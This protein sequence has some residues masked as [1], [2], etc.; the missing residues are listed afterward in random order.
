MSETPA[1][2]I[3]IVKKKKAHAAHHGGS[4]KVA[5]AD[6]VTAMMAFFLVMWII[7]MDQSTRELIQSYFNDP[8]SA[9]NSPAGISKLAAGGKKAVAMGS[10]GVMSGR[11]WGWALKEAQEQRFTRVRD[12]LQKQIARRPELSLLRK[13]VQ[14]AVSQSGLS[15]ELTEA[16]NSLFFQSGADQLSPPARQLLTIVAREL[17]Q[18]ANPV[19]IE[20]HTD[21]V[22]YSAGAG[23]TNWELSTDRANAARRLMQTVGLRPRQ[24]TEVRG[25]GDSKP[26]DARNPTSSINRRVS[27]LVPYD[28]PAAVEDGKSE[29]KV[30]K[31][32]HVP[33][34]VN[35][36]P[37]PLTDGDLS[38]GDN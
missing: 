23:Y 13:H 16:T 25:Y 18:L 8:A 1:P 26:R 21:S 2:V 11:I 20:G 5:Y 33:F 6:F 19:V 12:S 35:I 3:R 24:V 7:S 30:E 15:I 37:N 10:V 38:H 22:P 14:I 4:W 28:L 9:A 27:I 32:S 31:G 34:P 36:R 17:G 29:S